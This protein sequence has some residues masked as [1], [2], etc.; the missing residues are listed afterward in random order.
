MA[1]GQ[2]QFFQTASGGRSRLDK[3][4]HYLH[5]YLLSSIS[6]FF[7]LLSLFFALRVKPVE[8]MDAKDGE[9]CP[10]TSRVDSVS[11]SKRPLGGGAD[12]TN[13]HIICIG[14][15]YLQYQQSRHIV[16]LTVI[17]ATN[18]R[19]SCGWNME[20]AGLVT[21]VLQKKN[22]RRNECHGH[23]LRQS[24]NRHGDSVSFSK[25]PLGG[26]ADWTNHH[27]WSKE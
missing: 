13:H 23:S 20:Q 21:V 2:C 18:D 16:I 17:G 1:W 15:Y 3:P 14:I 27:K 26:G 22:G 7:L 5:R 25:R 19:G 9:W 11:F 10:C 4:P 8:V 12:W 6:V 24:F